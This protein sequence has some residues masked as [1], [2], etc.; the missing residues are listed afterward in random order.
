MKFKEFIGSPAL[1]IGGF[2]QLCILAFG[3][4]MGFPGGLLVLI[5]MFFVGCIMA[6]ARDEELHPEEIQYTVSFKATKKDLKTIVSDLGD[7]DPNRA[8]KIT[9]LGLRRIIHKVLENAESS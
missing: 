6:G 1:V 3:I 5:P 2:V 7:L 8:S 4:W 9:Y